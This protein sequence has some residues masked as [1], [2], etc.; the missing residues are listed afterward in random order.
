MARLY[1]IGRD[2]FGLLSIKN[3]NQIGI[4]GLVR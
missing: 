2:D 1:F 3:K 4:V